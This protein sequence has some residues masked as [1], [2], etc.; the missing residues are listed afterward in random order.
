MSAAYLLSAQRRLDRRA[1]LALLG[2]GLL[3]VL[4]VL[5]LGYQIGFTTELGAL[6]GLVAVVAVIIRPSLS[7]YMMLAAVVFIEQEQLVIPVGTDNLPIFHWPPRMAGFIERPIGLFLVLAL[8]A[9][10][11]QRFARREQLLRG[12][13]LAWPLAA[14]MACVGWGIIRGATSGGDIKIIVLEVRPYWYLALAYLLATNLITSVRQVHTMVW[15]IIAGA[16]LKSLQGT[17]IVFGVLGGHIGAYHEIMAHEESFFFVAL[18]LLIVVFV[19]YF[20]D[21]KQLIA[22]ACIL[23]FLLV[24]LVGNQRRADYVA[25]LIGLLVA[26][27][28]IIYVKRRAR[29]LL[30]TAL[31]SLVLLG[32]VYVVA[33]GNSGGALAQPARAVITVFKP[34]ATEAA[35]NQYRVIED[36]DLKYTARKNPLGYGFGKPFYQPAVL[37]NIQSLDQYYLYVPHNT[38]YWVLMRLG[39]IGDLAFWY[40]IGMIIVRITHVVKRL[41]TPYLK[42][43]AIYAVG[44]VFMEITL[45]FADYQLFFLRNVLFFGLIVG[46][47]LRFP[48][49]EEGKEALHAAAHRKSNTTHPW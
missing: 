23:P 18:M 20:R 40:L 2:G 49:L 4:G 41:R 36:Y 3:A 45:A 35:S 39:I 25:F 7:L 31:I 19:L 28:L 43:I 26:W 6:V 5:A 47:A 27:V 9:M 21:K 12:G 42:A 38:I 13:A 15:I 1:Y 8:A 29:G 32:G 33:F 37:P 10:L 30:L 14:L 17:Y 16:A 46:M 48:A 34:D 11:L 24:A 22:M 44:V